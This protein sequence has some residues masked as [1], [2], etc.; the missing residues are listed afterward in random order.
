MIRIEL[1][2]VY[3]LADDETI[4]EI[5]EKLRNTLGIQGIIIESLLITE[6]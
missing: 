3:E 2:S 6:D 1:E 5:E 4:E